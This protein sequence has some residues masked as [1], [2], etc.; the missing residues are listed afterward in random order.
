[1]PPKRPSANPVRQR[2]VQSASDASTE[3][4]AFEAEN[5]GVGVWRAFEAE[6][7]NVNGVRVFGV[8]E[9]CHAW[10]SAIRYIN[11]KGMK[12]MMPVV[13]RIVSR[14]ESEPPAL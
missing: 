2:G 8:R 13:A 5:N 1:M 3:L 9:F 7:N 12:P 14:L 10:R 4:R 11:I 6:T